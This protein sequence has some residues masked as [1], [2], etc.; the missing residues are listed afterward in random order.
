MKKTVVIGL[1]GAVMDAGGGP[2]RWQRWRPT[3]D[4]CRHE[5]LVVHRF[6]LLS[7]AR[8]FTK[9]AEQLTADITS[10]SPE[11]IVRTHSVEFQDAWD[12]QERLHRSPRL[13]LPVSV[14][15]REGKTT[16]STLPL[17]PTSPRICLFLL[18][19]AHYLPARL[20]Q[21]ALAGQS[22]KTKGEPG[23]YSIIDL[24][25]SKY[26]A[27]ASRFHQ[28]QTESLSFLKSGIDTRNAEFN[29]L[30]EQIE[31]VAIASKAKPRCS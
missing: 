15:P 17:A 7:Q 12:F 3:V 6:E 23:S 13:R 27:I 18:T 21:T 25:L 2:E 22:A 31:R 19:E 16:S 10:I 29:Q 9:L 26:D 28:E 4:L 30:I 5:D 20:I 14:Q 11:T 8:K 1:I 24:D